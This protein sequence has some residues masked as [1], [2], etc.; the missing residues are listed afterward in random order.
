M[1]TDATGAK[2]L[3]QTA[4]LDFY[5]TTAL[6]DNN[7]WEMGKRYTYNIVIGLDEIYFAPSVANWT[8]VAVN[9]INVQ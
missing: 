5:N 6:A 7:K 4:D 2:P 3:L 8:D 9:P 1:K